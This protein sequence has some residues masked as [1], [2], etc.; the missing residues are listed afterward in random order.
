MEQ[1]LFY[2]RILPERAQLSLQLALGFKHLTSGCSAQAKI[3]I[4]LNQ[5]AVWVDSESEWDIFDLRNVVRTIV[6]NELAMVGY[7]KGYAY[8]L[9]VTRVLNQSRGIDYVFGI[10]IPCLAARGQSIDPNEALPK[11]HEK[12]VGSNGVLLHRCF[13]DLVS[14][15][16]HA[17][18]TGF[19]CYRAIKSFRHHCAA[20]HGLSTDK[21]DKQWAHESSHFVKDSCWPYFVAKS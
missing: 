17:D 8:D 21:K 13:N 4:V 7:L 3:S 14:S 19:Y 5:L 18:D 12:I 1:Y 11:L 10:D 15:M 6:L 9:E 20:V 16:K 2:G